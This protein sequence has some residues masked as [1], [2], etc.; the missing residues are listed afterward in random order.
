M[1]YLKIFTISFTILI[2]LIS[3]YLLIIWIHGIVISFH[4]HPITGLLALIAEPAP[5]I[6]GIADMFWDYNIAEVF[7]EKFI[8]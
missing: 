5:I 2:V 7:T 3:F 6:I 1:N 4:A 8:K